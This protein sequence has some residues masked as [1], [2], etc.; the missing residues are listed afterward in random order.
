M[1][2]IMLI[3]LPILLCGIALFGGLF[4]GGL[5]SDQTF[6][7]WLNKRLAEYTHTVTVH[8]GEG[9]ADTVFTVREDLNWDINGIAMAIGNN[10]KDEMPHY[11]P[12]FIEDGGT[13]ADPDVT[14]F[15]ARHALKI[16]LPSGA[17]RD[18]YIFLGLFT[19]ADGGECY[20]NGAGYSL[21]TVTGDITLYA[22]WQSV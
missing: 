15:S 16:E 13:S 17:E 9:T 2:K 19:E 14:T 1:K 7:G 3:V 4:I 6:K 5:A 11:Y 10:G 12:E 18:G 20:V 21:R 22:H 8:W